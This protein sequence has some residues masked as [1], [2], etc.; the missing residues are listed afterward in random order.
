MLSLLLLLVAGDTALGDAA[1]FA[2][3]TSLLF[4]MPVATAI[5]V[6]RYRLYDLDLVIKKTVI[7]ALTVVLVMAVG[8][9][10]SIEYGHS[11]FLSWV[12]PMVLVMLPVNVLLL[13]EADD[14][15]RRARRTFDPPPPREPGLVRN[16]TLDYL[17]GGD[18]VGHGGRED[19]D[20]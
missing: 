11:V 13:H 7:F 18:L 8:L 1:W 3:V 14:A 4:A 10:V 15:G 9:G 16:L 12:I 20:A 5:A 6:L 2:F 19:G 17:A